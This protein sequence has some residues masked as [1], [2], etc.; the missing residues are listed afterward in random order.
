MIPEP[1]QPG[2]TVTFNTLPEFCAWMES[3]GYEIMQWGDEKITLRRKVGP[4]Y[5]RV[6]LHPNRSAFIPEVKR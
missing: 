1:I 4:L 3:L 2:E 5:E 6:E